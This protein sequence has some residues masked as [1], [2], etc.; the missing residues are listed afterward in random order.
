MH[1][2]QLF[3]YF[4]FL[5]SIQSAL[6]QPDSVAG[7]ISIGVRFHYG[8]VM[9]HRPSIVALQNNH[10]GGMDINIVEQTTGT[11]PWQQR[12]GYPRLGFK[13]GYYGLGNEKQLGHAY[14]LYPFADFDLGRYKT[15]NWNIQIGWG[16]GYIDKAFDLNENYKNV[17]I[18]SGANACFNLNVSAR[19][20]VTQKDRLYAGVGLT[21]FSNSSLVTP[22]LGVNLTTVQLQYSHLLGKTKAIKKQP[23]GPFQK[24]FRKS[25]YAA[26]FIKQ[27][28][29]AGGKYYFAG[30]ISADVVK[31]FSYKSGI[32]LGVDYFYDES[33]NSKLKNDE[34]KITPVVSASRI[35]I[36]ATYQMMVSKFTGSIAMG[37]YCYSN[38]NTDGSLYHRTGVRYM[39]SK[40]IFAT[41]NLKTHFGKADF[42]E[43]GI[44]YKW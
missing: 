9:A 36:S 5:F 10:L 6:A 34:K 35:G 4:F 15:F 2:K 27:I 14:A 43:V 20:L 28:Y 25:I 17:A 19:F 11:K 3:C 33:I 40:N 32:G 22:N 38:L 30:T 26:G 8:F 1:S 29:P 12:Y 13:F 39:V 7:N 42:L 44:G 16:I 21:H 18:G 37:Y 41:V 23:A 24:E 31:H